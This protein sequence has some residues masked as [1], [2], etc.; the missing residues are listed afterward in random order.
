MAKIAIV[1]HQTNVFSVYKTAK[2]ARENK[3]EEDVVIF[4]QEE[5]TAQVEA[6]RFNRQDLVEIYNYGVRIL[7]EGYEVEKP[8]FK[9]RKQ[10][11]TVN[12]G[13]EKLWELLEAYI[14]DEFMTKNDDSEP[15]SPR[16]IFVG[17]HITATDETLEVNP[18]R[19]RNP[20]D[21]EG[22]PARAWRALEVIRE[23]GSKGISYEEYLEKGGNAADLRRD[24]ERKRVIVNNSEGE[25]I[26][27]QDDRERK[28]EM[29]EA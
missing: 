16:G 13:V 28:A 22:E 24:L 6:E 1:I 4:S 11:K 26:V 15:K 21:P 14:E 19:K 25:E 8:T 23:A 18:R 20:R 10:F 7:Y 2:E 17:A 9:E 5:L 12:D 27:L 3:A 29:V